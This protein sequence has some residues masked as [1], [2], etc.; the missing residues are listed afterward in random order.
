MVFC[1]FQ[2]NDVTDKCSYS[3]SKNS[4]NKWGI[5]C[6]YQ[7]YCSS[8]GWSKSVRIKQSSQKRP[9]VSQWKQKI[10]NYLRVHSFIKQSYRY[11]NSNHK[12]KQFWIFA[13]VLFFHN[14]MIW[15]WIL[16]SKN[17]SKKYTI[18]RLFLKN[19]SLVCIKPVTTNKLKK[20][21]KNLT[22]KFFWV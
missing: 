4:K 7:E 2:K 15:F 17:K 21:P 19:L 1:K 6:Q 20:V 10:M 11:D 16:K 14:H 8:W 22:N 5:F 12:D 18:C 3:C 13:Y 9:S